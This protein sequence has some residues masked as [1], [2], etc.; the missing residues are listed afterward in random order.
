MI[1]EEL[2]GLRVLRFPTLRRTGVVCALSTV[3]QDV[4]DPKDRARL[5]EAAGFDPGRVASPRQVH[6]AQV[7]KA[8]KGALAEETEADAVI[9]DLPGQPVLL[10]G[11][12]CSLI[13]VVDP[14]IRAFGIAHAGWKGSARGI[15][16][17]LVRALEVHYG[18]VPAEC[19]AAIGPTIGPDRYV[20]GPEVAAAFIKHR[21]WAKRYVHSKEGRLHLDLAGINRHFLFEAGIPEANIEVCRMC[22]YESAGLLHSFRRDGA[23][24]GHHGL[25]AGFP[26]SGA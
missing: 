12:D 17:Q 13:I 25:L 1:A 10:R 4:R 7:I 26:E 23:G 8:E 22:T 20:V 16:I 14:E 21:T 6:H 2:G 11:A 9:S 3:P 19:R 24:C 5:A 18:A 15:V